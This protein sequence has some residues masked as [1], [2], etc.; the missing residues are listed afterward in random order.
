MTCCPCN[1]FPRHIWWFVGQGQTKCISKSRKFKNSSLP[2]V[3]SLVNPGKGLLP[4][5]RGSAQC[6]T[7]SWASFWAHC[8]L[9]SWY[10]PK[11]SVELTQQAAP[12]KS[13]SEAV[14]IYFSLPWTDVGLEH[15]SARKTFGSAVSDVKVYCVSGLSVYNCCNTHLSPT[16][17]EVFSLKTLWL[18]QFKFILW[19]YIPAFK[20]HPDE[21]VFICEN[22]WESEKKNQSVGQSTKYSNY[23]KLR[24]LNGCF[25]F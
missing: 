4:S 6:S 22:Q 11:Y 9:Q 25:D 21:R 8:N 7:P 24:L 2:G 23:R 16:F 15:H 17:P 10:E 1:G 19:H 5:P 12:L 3:L 14:K 20:L 18:L 13:E